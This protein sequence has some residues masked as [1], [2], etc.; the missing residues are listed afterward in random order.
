LWQVRRAA[1]AAAG[2]LPYEAALAQ[3]EPSVMAERSS[4]TRGGPPLPTDLASAT[5]DQVVNAIHKPLLQAAVLRGLRLCG[6]PDRI[7]ANL[8]TADHEWIATKAL[9]EL[10]KLPERG[11]A[12]GRRLRDLIAG[13]TW[14]DDR[15]V[16]ALLDRLE[17]AP[18]PNIGSRP[19]AVHIA[20]PAQLST[21]LPLTYKAAVLVLSGGASAP[22]PTGSL[23][24]EPLTSEECEALIGLANPAKD[25]ER[26]QT[27]FTP[28][29]SFTRNGHRVSQRVTT[30][31]GESFLPDRL[32]PAIAAANRI[33]LPIPWHTALLEG[34]L[35]ETYAFDFL[36][37]LAAQGDDA[38]FYAALAE[39][40]ET[41]MPV[42]CQKSQTL[43]TQFKIDGRLIPTLSRFL[44]VGGDDVFGGLCVLAKCIDIPEILPILEGLL[45][46]WIQRFD[47]KAIGLQNEESDFLWRGFAR[48]TEHPRFDAI[49]DWPRELEAVLLAS[50]SPHRAQSI[51]RVMERDP[52]S[53]VV[54]EARLFNEGNWDHY[55]VDEV[56]R[57]DRA[58]EAL[59]SQAQDS[60]VAASN[61]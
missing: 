18:V 33:G 12:L 9:S 17:V 38:R 11:P 14:A 28:A 53:Y 10:S 16:N 25:P 23:V 47:V 19:A 57:L 4:P 48:L 42:L 22:L 56:D 52:R 20:V 15:V 3:I 44:A 46:R 8:A 39:A 51:V 60:R 2:R 1:I 61:L 55:E 50:I 36:S 30:H 26:G 49:P 6:R 45:H 32:R 31:R 54:I 40:E 35:G 29:V 24:L 58:A 43:S 21:S 27:V 37:C 59:F 5:P 34:P 7:E 13:A 41:L